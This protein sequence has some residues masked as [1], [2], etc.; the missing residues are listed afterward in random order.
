[1]SGRLGGGGISCPLVNDTGSPNWLL[2]S[3]AAILASGCS[4]A[5]WAQTSAVAE[6]EDAFG[7]RVG[8]ETVGLYNETQV[9][10]FNLENAG[11]YRLDDHYFVRSGQLPDALV[12]GSTV[13]VG[14][15]ALEVDFPAP[16]GLVE[17]S[18]RRPGVGRFGADGTAGARWAGS[19]FFRAHGWARS[20]NSDA[21]ILGGFEMAPGATFPDGTQGSE[22]SFGTI[23]NIR[24]G[25]LALQALFGGVERHYNGDYAFFSTGPVLPSPL[26]GRY[27]MF[28][29][30]WGKFRTSERMLG[31]TAAWRAS[32]DLDLSVAYFHSWART[33]EAD[34]TAL[35]L[36][37]ARQA[38]AT[39]FQ[40]R[41][42][43]RNGGSGE[44]KVRKRFTSGEFN[45]ELIL[46]IRTS[47]SD[48]LNTA[49]EAHDLGIVNLKTRD[50]GPAAAPAGNA[51][52]ALTRSRQTGS[53]VTYRTT[54]RDFLRLNVGAMHADYRKTVDVEMEHN[55]SHQA[56]WL[57]D[58]AISIAPKSS[59]LLYA[60]YAKGL[61]E[62]G[63]VPNAA[64]NRNEVLPSIIAEQLELGFRYR[65]GKLTSTGAVFEI[66]KP[67]T[68]FDAAGRFGLIGEVRHRGAEFSLAGTVSRYLTA[69]VGA[70]FL[71]PRVS[72]RIVDDG[73][74]ARRP[75]GV[76]SSVLQASGS[77]V[78]PFAPDFSL[79]AILTHTS[80]VPADQLDRF[81]IPANTTL[82]LGAQYTFGAA[83][84]SHILRLR[85]QDLFGRTRWQAAPG[86]ALIRE[87]PRSLSLQIT[88][89]I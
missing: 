22:T 43:R 72:G 41:D 24:A 68:G 61:E 21:A 1:M 35:E 83:G 27:Q 79:D 56:P 82:D 47:E 4:S 53:G 42:Q 52:Y 14:A 50:F 49:G 81:R 87:Q 64:I 37:D 70:V 57:F 29:P 20:R 6:A 74:A 84:L 30:E 76:A 11:N 45:Q 17:F 12:D 86:G 69:A 40:A 13:R 67:T 51:A 15:S 8:D 5:V 58:A 9:R 2:V 38:Q 63:V 71:R 60:S 66:W 44:L 59:S 26:L 18:L 62:A 28:G 25:K 77:F 16:S 78:L 85:V 23:G 89:L 46:A 39:I 33:P 32:S 31:G 75:L 7:Q 73:M 55:R 80:S 65:F 48:S 88:S 3:A 54:Y 36:V 10:G 34:F 19:P